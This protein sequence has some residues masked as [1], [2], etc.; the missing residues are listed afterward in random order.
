MVARGCQQSP[1]SNRTGPH[2]RTFSDI[3]NFQRSNIRRPVAPR[4]QGSAQKQ[5]DDLFGLH[6]ERRL[7]IFLKGIL[8]ADDALQALDLGIDGIIVSN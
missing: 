5:R 1:F 8:S 4:S 6:R 7:P 2:G 3:L